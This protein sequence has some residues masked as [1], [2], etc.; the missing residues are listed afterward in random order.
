MS[1]VRLCK[2]Q[3]EIYLF[4]AIWKHGNH[5]TLFLFNTHEYQET[6]FKNPL[7][8]ILSFGLVKNFLKVK[9]CIA[10]KGHFHKRLSKDSYNINKLMVKN[11]KW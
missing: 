8:P 1:D 10:K 2:K 7:D 5:G 9:N 6:E 3:L 11:M 4:I